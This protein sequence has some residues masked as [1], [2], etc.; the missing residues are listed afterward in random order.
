M[1]GHLEIFINPEHLI[2]SSY[3]RIGKKSHTLLKF[4]VGKKIL[5]LNEGG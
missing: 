5:L 2:L 4:R 1:Q 3:S